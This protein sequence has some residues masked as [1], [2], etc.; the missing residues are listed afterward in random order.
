MRHHW[1]FAE[2]AQV[3][4]ANNMS[5][6]ESLSAAKSTH[7]KPQSISTARTGKAELPRT[8]SRPSS[9]FDFC[10]KGWGH[11]PLLTIAETP[12]HPEF[13]DFGF[14]FSD[15]VM[16]R[17]EST[18][19]LR[20][21]RL[22]IAYSR[23]KPGRY[24]QIFYRVS[25]PHE[26]NRT[27]VGCKVFAAYYSSNRICK[28]VRRS[29]AESDFYV[30]P[31]RNAIVGMLPA[32]LKIRELRTVLESEHLGRIVKRA[33]R[34][35]EMRVDRSKPLEVVSY[36]P[37]RYCL[38]RFTVDDIDSRAKIAYGRIHASG[39]EAERTFA[40]TER[41]A[42]RPNRDDSVVQVPEP[43]GYDRPSRIFFHRSVEG[44]TLTSQFGSAA[45][46]NQLRTTAKALAELHALSGGTTS[47]SVDFNSDI[48]ILTEVANW[49]TEAYPDRAAFFISVV[50][51]LANNVP[52][53]ERD[54]LIHGD[55]SSN[56]VLV[57][58][59][60]V[61]IIDWNSVKSGD[62]HRD[63]A[64]FAVRLRRFLSADEANE[65]CERFLAAYSETRQVKLDK[66][67]LC[68]HEAHSQIREA[69]ANFRKLKPGWP[70]RFDSWIAMAERTLSGLNTTRH[71]IA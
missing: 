41:L 2:S 18:T 62:P 70:Q 56:Q 29:G 68:W 30:W 5:Q 69:I 12:V 38:L 65:V 66:R 55:F 4:L 57:K 48:R 34:K 22:T 25:E 24:C 36:R 11:L 26:T 7:A 54:C 6:Y 19:G 39:A 44:D 47:C 14:F 8:A 28:A 67:T 51:S 10:A 59:S 20:G 17:I 9:A 40:I 32:D 15:Y 61:T 64:S 46:G 52:M 35:Q 50:Q 71:R 42:N 58:G 33:T 60:N 49:L 53:C 37:E 16:N 31:D 27:L 1:R 63:L 43:L 13:P 23:L 3:S 45:F 21:S